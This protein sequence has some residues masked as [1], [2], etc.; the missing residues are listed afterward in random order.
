MSDCFN[1]DVHSDEK[2][3]ISMTLSSCVSTTVKGTDD[4][5]IDD[6]VKFLWYELVIGL[7]VGN[8]GSDY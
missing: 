5:V 7:L 6:G 1:K 3:R 2:C 4:E 8:S